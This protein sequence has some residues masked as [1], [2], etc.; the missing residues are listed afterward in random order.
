MPAVA[1]DAASVILLRD[2]PSGD[3][4]DVLMVRRH[5]RS[6]FA[7]DMHVFPGGAVEE[8]DCEEG[9]AAFC[10]GICQKDAASDPDSH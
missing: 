3:G 2:D 6:E 1:R 8:A 5:A 9:M 7:G 4:M 10:D